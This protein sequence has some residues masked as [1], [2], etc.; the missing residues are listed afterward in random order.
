VNR[1]SNGLPAGSKHS[2]RIC[3]PDVL[4]AHLPTLQRAGLSLIAVACRLPSIG[5]GVARPGIFTIHCPTALC[6]TALTP[7]AELNWLTMY[8]PGM[9]M[10]TVLAAGKVP[11]GTVAAPFHSTKPNLSGTAAWAGVATVSAPRTAA[12]PS[13]RSLVLMVNRTSWET[14][15]RLRIEATTYLDHYGVS[16]CGHRSSPRYP[17]TRADRSW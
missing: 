12:V 13:A 7:P 11:D 4:D 9:R 8:L 1:V 14:R 3:C 17:F 6:P 5:P 16:S 10:P 2:T 15:R